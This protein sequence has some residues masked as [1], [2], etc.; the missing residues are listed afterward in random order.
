MLIG[1]GVILMFKFYMGLAIMCAIFSIMAVFFSDHGAALA[2][3]FLGM[4]GAFMAIAFV[5]A[6]PE[7]RW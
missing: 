6:N 2:T 1:K 5:T 7:S 4:G 3:V